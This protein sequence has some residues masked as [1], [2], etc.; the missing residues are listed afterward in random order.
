MKSSLSY[1]NS[2][3]EMY[4]KSQ[5]TGHALVLVLAITTLFPRLYTSVFPDNIKRKKFNV[6][7][8]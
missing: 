3:K 6:L 1:R 2:V 4:L 5:E 8:F 7:H